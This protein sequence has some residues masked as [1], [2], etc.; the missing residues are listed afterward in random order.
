MTEQQWR[1]SANPKAMLDFVLARR[2]EWPGR[3]AS[4]RGKGKRRELLEAFL[5]AEE[6]RLR[7]FGV[8]CCRRV[9]E[10]LADARSRRAVEA[11]ER[12]ADG[13][14][15]REQLRAAA[16]S[17]H[18]AVTEALGEWQRGA[19]TW[20]VRE[21]S[22]VETADAAWRTALPDEDFASGLHMIHLR[23]AFP[24]QAARRTS[25]RQQAALLRDVFNPFRTV[26]FDPA[27]RTPDVVALAEAAYQERTL[28]SGTLEPARLAVLADA[29]E[30]AGCAD[31]EVLAHLRGPGPHVR[32]CWVV[33]LLLGK[34]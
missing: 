8:A 16:K 10:L 25:R 18:S 2:K 4:A 9:W 11:A 30:D 29:L 24:A 7:L 5:G 21:D 14:L 12:F 32:G 31:K 13:A 27:W 17:A 20:D 23:T 15:S 28:P 3:L 1:R 19:R 34:G 33:D 22:G 26:S 6:R